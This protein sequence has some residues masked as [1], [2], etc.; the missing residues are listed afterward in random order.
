MS[1]WP[2]PH[3][4]DTLTLASPVSTM[5]ASLMA[6]AMGRVGSGAG[7]NLHTCHKTWL[8]W[9]HSELC[10]YKS[11]H[12]DTIVLCSIQIS[13]FITIKDKEEGN[14]MKSLNAQKKKSSHFVAQFNSLVFAIFKV[15]KKKRKEMELQRWISVS[16]ETYEVDLR[17]RTGKKPFDTYN[18][19]T[20]VRQTKAMIYKQMNG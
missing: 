3:E 1:T 4:A 15:E 5:T 16:S 18:N 11:N 19:L 2:C 20:R 9:Y 7:I 14:H 13:T 17:K 6:A 12:V 8:N 10:Q